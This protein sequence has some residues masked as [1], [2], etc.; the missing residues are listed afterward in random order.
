M[1]RMAEF[2]TVGRVGD[3]PEGDCAVV[4]IGGRPVAV[5]HVGGQY[6]A[7][8][9]TCPHMGASLAGGAVEAGVVTCPW[10]GWRFRLKDGTWA[11]NPR[12]KTGCYAVRVVGDQIQVERP[13]S[14]PSA[15]SEPGA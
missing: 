9:D 10:H 11:D 4:Q 6:Y 12:L 8:D 1:T 15:K 7:L 5:F 2:V 14:D 3:L 13:G